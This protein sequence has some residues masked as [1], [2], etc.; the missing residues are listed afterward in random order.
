LISVLEPVVHPHGSNEDGGRRV[1]GLRG[2]L[3]PAAECPDVCRDIAQLGRGIPFFE[4][5]SVAPVRLSDPVITP[6]TGVTHLAY[7]VRR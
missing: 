6:G 5:L 4:R 3:E 7:E 2:K 1:V